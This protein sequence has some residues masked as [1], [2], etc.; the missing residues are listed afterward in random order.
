[1]SWDVSL[2]PAEG[3]PAPGKEIPEDWSPAPLGTAAEVRS[4]IADVLPAVVWDDKGWGTLEGTGWSIEFNFGR[5]DPV[6]SVMLHIRGNGNPLS[7]LSALCQRN[8]WAAL[9]LSTGEFLDLSAPSAKGWKEF[10][11]FRD[12]LL[13]I[14]QKRSE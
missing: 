5:K 1:M 4:R 9:D 8:S 11:Q 12:Q 7:V 2:F 6:E 13:R 14:F 10:R 3:A